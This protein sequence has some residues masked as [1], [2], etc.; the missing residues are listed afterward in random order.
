MK[1]LTSRRLINICLTVVS[2]TLLLVLYII[3]TGNL[4]PAGFYSGWFLFA[5]I[6]FL[7]LYNVRKSLSFLPLGS[8]ASWLQFHIYCGFLSYGLFAVHVQ[9]SI[10]NGIFECC[11]ALIYMSVFLSGVIGLY[12]TR[13][14]PG[15]LTSL[16]N[17]V[18]FEHIPVARRQ[19]RDQIASLMLP[20]IRSAEL[21]STA[22][23]E[24]YRDRVQPFLNSDQNVIVHLM[25]NAERRHQAFMN[26]LA[27]QDRYL[28]AK[29]RDRLAEVKNLL[30]RK[31]QVETQYSLQAALKGWLFFHIPATYALLIFG[32]FHG[33]LVHAWRGGL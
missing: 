5:V 7:A 23:A 28:N 3:G 29:E 14:Y 21:E 12:I 25:R 13:V 31:H 24:L 18:I 6:V 16:G 2:A 30:N 22:L 11:L 15:R 1:P 10:P 9:F 8:S 4:R 20:S 33:V 32:F 26:T 27:D 19:L 17:E